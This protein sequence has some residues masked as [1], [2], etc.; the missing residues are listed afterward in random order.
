MYPDRYYFTR[1]NRWKYSLGMYVPQEVSIELAKRMRMPY[2]FLKASNSPYYEN[3]KYY[4]EMVE[5]MK[6]HNDKF[7]CHMIEGTHHLHLTHPESVSGIISDFLIKHRME[8][9]ETSKAKL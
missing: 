2:L 3:K 8:A 6:K 5:V 4:D 7:E 9:S 1:D